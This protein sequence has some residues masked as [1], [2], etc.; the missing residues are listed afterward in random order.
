MC[1]ELSL[2]YTT[3]LH[4]T[5]DKKQKE[6]TE[7]Q[8]LQCVTLFWSFGAEAEKSIIMDIFFH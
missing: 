8:S 3:V 7:I 6:D 1:R 2:Q 4:S 5:G